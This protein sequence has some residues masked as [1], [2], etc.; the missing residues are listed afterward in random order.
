MINNTNVSNVCLIEC[1]EEVCACIRESNLSINC[2]EIKD[3][4]THEIDINK[5]KSWFESN[6]NNFKNKTNPNSY[7]KKAFLAELSKGKFELDEISIDTSSLMRAL[8]F[9]GINTTPDDSGYA[10]IMW[11]EIIRAGMSVESVV[12]LNHKIVKYLAK[13]QTFED[14]VSLVKRSNAIKAYNIDWERIQQRYASLLNEWNQE[15]ESTRGIYET[16][17][18]D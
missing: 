5:F 11:E 12:E 7:F 18:D 16:E 15:I 17:Q 10:E 2:D 3:A 8:R 9:K 4:L 1:K 13:E 14:Y 6:T